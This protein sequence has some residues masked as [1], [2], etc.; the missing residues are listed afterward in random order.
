MTDESYKSISWAF[1]GG[2][3]HKQQSWATN[4][5]EEESW[6]DFFCQNRWNRCVCIW[7]W[8]M[9]NQ[10]ILETCHSAV[11]LAG[12]SIALSEISDCADK[13]RLHHTQDWNDRMRF[14]ASLFCSYIYTHDDVGQD[15]G[16]VTWHS[17]KQH[18]DM[19]ATEW[20]G[21]GEQHTDMHLSEII[22]H[23]TEEFLSLKIS[24][25]DP[26]RGITFSLR[27]RTEV[28][29]GKCFLWG[30]AT[31]NSC[32]RQIA[33]ERR[34]PCWILFWNQ[35]RWDSLPHQIILVYLVGRVVYFFL[36]NAK[37]ALAARRDRDQSLGDW[38]A[39]QK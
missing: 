20:D 18:W 29:G 24:P 13:G 38:H 27:G 19:R 32:D 21:N 28:R 36:E 5:W 39:V 34:S 26:S 30:G 8:R 9:S 23:Y 2:S 15:P 25:P 14:A 3:K 31:S 22:Q 6:N 10:G 37:R 17:H 1:G 16:V 35:C 33:T 12:T 7:C 11:D 4:G